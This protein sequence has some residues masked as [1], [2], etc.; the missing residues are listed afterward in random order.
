VEG[1]WNLVFLAVILGAVFISQPPFLREG[2]MLA[3]AAG[4][5]FT[6]RKTV[7][8]AN[9]FDFH[10]LLEV[11]ILFLGIFATMMPALDWLQGHA[12]MA[13][14]ANPSPALF[15]WGSGTFSSLLDNAPTYL[16]FFSAWLGLEGLA[17]GQPDK[18]AQILAPGHSQAALTALSVASVFFGGCTYIGNA[19][20]F[21]V[22]AIAERQGVP[23]PGFLGY[24]IKWTVPILL[25][26]LIM[27]WLIF[28][29]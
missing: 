13:L 25:P 28:F 11:A 20:N 10:P 4:S 15:Y 26:L 22:K 29:R 14:G 9:R 23:L 24:V 21:M 18:L 17:P 5:W 12:R 2:V 16:S 3:A 1:L 19:P 27:I 7:H 6:T 8:E